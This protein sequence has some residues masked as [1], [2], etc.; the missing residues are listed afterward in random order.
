MITKIELK[1]EVM[2]N[3]E[4]CLKIFSS[5]CEKWRIT[6]RKKG[7]EFNSLSKTISNSLYLLASVDFSSLLALESKGTNVYWFID[8]AFHWCFK[9]NKMSHL[10]KLM[11]GKDWTANLVNRSSDK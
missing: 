6:Q 11:N 2:K 7:L 9:N 5:M 3:L 1:T 8:K 4:K 10:I